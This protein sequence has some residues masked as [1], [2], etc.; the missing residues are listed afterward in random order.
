MDKLYYRSD[1]EKYL[2]KQGLPHSHPTIIRYEKAGI[3]PSPRNQI[4]TQKSRV[5]TWEEILEIGKILKDKIR[6]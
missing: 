5:Y 2:K 4:Q 3:I 6:G 1:L